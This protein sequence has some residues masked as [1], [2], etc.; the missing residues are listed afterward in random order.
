M[1]VRVEGSLELLSQEEWDRYLGVGLFNDM[2]IEEAKLGASSDIIQSFG[3][4]LLYGLLMGHN[5]KC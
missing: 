4:P 5:N 3:R 1:N 2:R